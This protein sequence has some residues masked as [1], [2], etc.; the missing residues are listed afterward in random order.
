MKTTLS[1]VLHMVLG[2]AIAAGVTFPTYYGFV[3]L[4]VRP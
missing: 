2:L 3:A 1:Y 4:G